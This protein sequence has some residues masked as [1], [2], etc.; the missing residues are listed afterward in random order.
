MKNNRPG[1]T[2][3]ELL[4]V[5]TIIGILMGL[6]IPAVNAAREA[7]RRN[8]CATQMKNLALAAIQHE[9]AKG[10]LPGYLQNYGTYTGT[11]TPADPADPTAAAP[12]AHAKLGTWV[13]ALM[14]FLDA[15]PTYEIWTEDRYPILSGGGGELAPTNEQRGAGVGFH[16]RSAP[17]LAIMQCPSNPNSD[18]EFAR[19]SYVSN[20]GMFALPTST[21]SA[22]SPGTLVSFAQSMER[23][24]GAFNNKFNGPVSASVPAAVGSKVRLDD[25]KDGQGYTMLFSENV[26]ALPWNRPG[27]A[28]ASELS[29][30]TVAYPP[31]A[32]YTQGM[33]WFYE[34]PQPSSMGAA[35]WSH[36]VPGAVNPKHK[37]NGRGTAANESI[38]VESMTNLS[39]GTNVWDLARPSSAHV[40]GVNIGMADGGTRSITN[41]ID[42]RVYQALMTPRGKSSDVPWQ[43]YVMDEDAI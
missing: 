43:E 11:G 14:P 37:I 38:F 8:Q 22:A 10:E 35:L 24:N 6:L 1:F 25:M 20:N 16:Q 21:G 34:D 2:L 17:N 42:Y 4:V 31:E 3:V 7:A 32:R 40:D 9:N 23:A 28:N 39:P 12:A 15:Q 13:V 36:G 18:G 19:N 29:A 27:F 30:P 26:Q 33:L 41:S 5:I